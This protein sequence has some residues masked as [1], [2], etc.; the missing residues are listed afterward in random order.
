MA[1]LVCLAAAGFTGVR[2]DGSTTYEDAYVREAEG[3]RRWVIGNEALSYTLAVDRDD[4]VAVS[5]GRG[6]EA[7]PLGARPDTV[8]APNG[9][10]RPF[11]R[12]T[13]GFVFL[14]AEENLVWQPDRFFVTR[15]FGY[16]AMKVAF[17][18]RPCREFLSREFKE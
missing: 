15:A 11:G 2:A 14:G 17:G 12:S 6:G 4:L 5:L 7:V 13:A 16:G 18:L 3:G 1:L 10:E 8:V 9:D